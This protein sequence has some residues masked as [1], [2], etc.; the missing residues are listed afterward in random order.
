MRMLYQIILSFSLAMCVLFAISFYSMEMQIL[1]PEEQEKLKEGKTFWNWETPTG[2]Y[3]MH[4][5]EKGSGPNHVILLH[6]F[7]ANTFT[8]RYMIDPLAE[9]GFHVWAVDLLGFGFSDKP[10]E[11]QYTLDF[12]LDQ[13]N[14]FMEGQDIPKAHFVGSSMGGG[15][16]LWMSLYHPQRINSLTLIGALGYPLD[17]PIY[18]SIGKHIGHFWM[19]FLGPSMVRKGLEQV[20]YSEDSITPDQIHA[21]SL[22]YCFPGGAMA[23]LNT[24]KNFDNQR[25]KDLSTRYIREI[26]YPLLIIWGKQDNLIPFHHFEQFC[27]DFPKARK[28]LIPQCGHI[29]QEEKP[30][31][32]QLGIIDF[33]KQVKEVNPQ[34]VN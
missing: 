14:A 28:M 5:V 19:P 27:H 12:F 16:S 24:L 30:E 17:L 4:Y 13:I 7:R 1:S 8:W 22:P 34:T 11:V 33:L 25:L 9:A 23:S 6:G 10:E 15:L 32:V 20:V 21:Y 18:V 2:N 3:A 29:P 26:T 31:I